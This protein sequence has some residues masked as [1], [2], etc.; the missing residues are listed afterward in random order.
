[1]RD[2]DKSKAQLIEELTRLRQSEERYR[3]MAEFADDWEYLLGPDGSTTYVAPSVEHMTGYAPEAFYADPHL[4][5]KLVHPDDLGRFRAHLAELRLERRPFCQGLEFRIID[6]HGVVLWLEHR[7]Q[8]I[9]RSDGSYAGQRACNRNVTRRR[10]AA[11]Q[12]HLAEQRL[13]A[14][15]DASLESVLLMDKAGRVLLANQSALDRFG[16]DAATVRHTSLYELLP[17]QVADHRRE[18]VERVIETGIPARFVDER[19]GRT[20]LNSIYPVLGD[21]QTVDNVVVYGTDITDE[22]RVQADLEHS[23]R[24]LAEANL[25]L[26]LVIDT[27]P[28]RIF[29]KDRDSNYLGCNRHFAADAGRDNPSDLVGT[30]DFELNWKD[31]A[32]TYREEDREVVV[33]RR[34]KVNYERMQTSPTGART[35]RVTTKVPL[36]DLDGNVIG[37]LGTYED[38]TARK[39]IE[40]RLRESEARHRSYFHDSHAVQLIVEP[41]S[42]RILDANP[43]ACHFYGYSLDEM[44]EKNITDINASPPEEVFE[45]MARAK[46]EQRSHFLFR[47]RLANGELCPVEVYSGP[48]FSGTRPILFSIVHD[49]SKRKQAEEERERLIVELRDALS[50]IKTL[51]GL[52]PICSACKKIRNDQGYWEHLE[53]YIRQHSNADFTHGICPDCLQKLYPDLVDEMR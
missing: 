12:L 18:T 46:S 20:I 35:W 40:E 5:E 38:V 48:A 52:L 29:W 50:R 4:V 22:R 8:P 28:V 31:M 7:C 24:L 41:E 37:V 2:E 25:L 19:L 45:E 42:G 44:Q 32:E 27:I 51:S 1:M 33:F 26:R 21:S 3:I 39:E 6:K 43:A 10:Q 30:T 23:Q 16:T 49:I 14:I 17:E 47:H 13:R 9:L 34:S 15:L 53:G 11:E 36:V